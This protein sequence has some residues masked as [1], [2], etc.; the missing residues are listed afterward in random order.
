ML[1]EIEIGENPLGIKIFING[2]PTLECVP[3]E[4]LD[5]LVS[6]AE[7]TIY[8]MFVKNEKRKKYKKWYCRDFRTPSKNYKISYWQRQK[9]SV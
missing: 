8:E 3:E 7:V 4:E 2:E 1:K 9:S 5:T 6:Q